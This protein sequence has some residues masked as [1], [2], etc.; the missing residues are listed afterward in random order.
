MFISPA[1][2]AESL[3]NIN[4]KSNIS[5]TISELSSDCPDVSASISCYSK[6]LSNSF[7][8]I[9]G[10]RQIKL[11]PYYYERHT[12]NHAGIPESCRHLQG[13]T[14]PDNKIEEIKNIRMSC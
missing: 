13:L 7:K 3:I 10:K 9:Y 6:D 5:E 2:M 14:L 12:S 1:L 11:Y 4:A 8:K